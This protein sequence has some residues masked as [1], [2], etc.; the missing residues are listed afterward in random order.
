MS[1]FQKYLK[2]K[3]KYLTLKQQLS[4]LGGGEGEDL[5]PIEV[6]PLNTEDQ[7]TEMFSASA[8]EEEQV[9]GEDE[10]DDKDEEQEQEQEQEDEEQ[11]DEEA[12]EGEEQEGGNL[13]EMAT[14]EYSSSESD[15]ESLLGG[16]DSDT[17][18]YLS[19]EASEDSDMEQAGGA[20]FNHVIDN[21]SSS[22]KSFDLQKGNF[23][24][25]L[26]SLSE[27]SI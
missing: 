23:D 17:D 7:P 12:E 1:Y 8:T 11:E 26:S 25:E 5:S 27:F 2:Y 16:G 15:V 14:S 18:S 9:G 3:H 22:V 13:T 20:F 6:G 19:D 10:E 21:L 24:S 4:Q